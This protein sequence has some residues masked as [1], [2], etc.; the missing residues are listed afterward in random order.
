VA[1]SCFA[2]VALISYQLLHHFSPL[3]YVFTDDYAQFG[4]FYKTIYL[5]FA[6]L[7][8][9]SQYYFIWM[10]AECTVIPAFFVIVLKN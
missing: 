4:Q 10:L 5:H 7:G 6:Q 3:K 1:R 9:R 2:I 8:W